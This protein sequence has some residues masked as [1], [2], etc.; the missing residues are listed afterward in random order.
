MPSS[1]TTVS[2]TAFDFL[3]GVRITGGMT[4]GAGVTGTG[5]TGAGVTTGTVGTEEDG[6]TGAVATEAGAGAEADR[7]RVLSPPVKTTGVAGE[8][9]VM[10]FSR[11]VEI[12]LKNK[13]KVAFSVLLYLITLESSA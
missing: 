1:P 8:T 12:E 6:V 10:T 2:G 11:S 9:T 4:I 5:V 3:L 13:G 7:I